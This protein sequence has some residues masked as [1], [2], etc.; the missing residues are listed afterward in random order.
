MYAVQSRDYLIVA[1]FQKFT[2]AMAYLRA[3]IEAG[4]SGLKIIRLSK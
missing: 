3:C 1:T 4:E 2:Q